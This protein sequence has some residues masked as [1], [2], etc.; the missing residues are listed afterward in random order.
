MHLSRSLKEGNVGTYTGLCA[1]ILCIFYMRISHTCLVSLIRKEIFQKLK[2]FP[3]SWLMYIVEL[4]KG[5]KMCYVYLPV[6]IG[7]IELAIIL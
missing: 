6:N 2:T 7:S 3:T 1:C 4:M 5:S